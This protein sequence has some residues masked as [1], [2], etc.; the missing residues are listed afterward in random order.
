M[1]EAIDELYEH[2]SIGVQ[3]LNAHLNHLLNDDLTETE[4]IDRELIEAWMVLVHQHG[5]TDSEN[6]VA[7]LQRDF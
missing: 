5:I 3:E 1:I 7:G 6:Q 2:Y 4:R